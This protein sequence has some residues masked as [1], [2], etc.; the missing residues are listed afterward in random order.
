MLVHG[1]LGNCP[2]QMRTNLVKPRLNSTKVNFLGRLGT[3]L[4]KP[5]KLF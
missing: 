2:I 1:K 4:I 5:G 3:K